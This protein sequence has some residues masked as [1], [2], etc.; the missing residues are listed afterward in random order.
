MTSW[1]RWCCWTSL[2][3]AIKQLLGL[4]REGLDPPRPSPSTARPVA[5]QPCRGT[6]A[7]GGSQPPQV[8]S[9]EELLLWQPRWCPA[10]TPRTTRGPDPPPALSDQECSPC[11]ES[12]A[13][14]AAQPGGAGAPSALPAPAEP[15]ELGWGP[16]GDRRTGQEDTQLLWWHLGLFG[17]RG[18]GQA[19]TATGPPRAP[20][21]AAG[22]RAAKAKTRLAPVPQC[23]GAVSAA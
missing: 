2:S 22:T 5:A 7:R 12:T 15:P 14:P 13:F 3:P 23:A 8:L 1:T 4:H 19:G 17:C 9:G 11:W 6:G 20:Q 18:K 16:G 21:G 10:T